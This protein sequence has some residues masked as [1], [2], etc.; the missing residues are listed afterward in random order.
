MYDGVTLLYSR[1]WHNIINQL[2]FNK[3]FVFLGLHLPHMKVPRQGGQP[4]CSCWPTLQPQECQ[5]QASTVTYP[6]AH[7]NTGSLT[8]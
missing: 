3:I 7:S 2:D 8:P 5:I 4:N 6:T 1:N